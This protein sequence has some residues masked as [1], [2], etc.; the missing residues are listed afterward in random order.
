MNGSE[1]RAF[2]TR[3]A[4]SDRFLLS[5]DAA[6]DDDEE[7]E[8]TMVP[9]IEVIDPKCKKRYV[10]D[11]NKKSDNLPWANR[12]WP[13]SCCGSMTH[14]EDLFSLLL[15]NLPPQDSGLIPSGADTNNLGILI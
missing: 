6:N 3:R 7:D 2:L 5:E 12:S 1:L 11:G 9:R 10:N 14:Q 13:S 8:S 4:D 15:K